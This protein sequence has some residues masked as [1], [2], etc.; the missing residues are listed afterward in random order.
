MIGADTLRQL[1][2]LAPLVQSLA[3]VIQL[4]DMDDAPEAADALAA[5]AGPP[6]RVGLAELNAAQAGRTRPRMQPAPEVSRETIPS[7]LVA[8]AG[9]REL[10]NGLD[11]IAELVVQSFRDR[12]SGSRIIASHVSAYPEDQKIIGGEID[13]LRTA[14]LVASGGLCSPV[15]AFYATDTLVATDARRP[16][17]DSLPSFNAD[18]G[19]VTWNPSPHLSDILID[20]S[21]AAITTVTVAQDAA[22]GTKTVQEVSCGSASTVQVEAIAAR[23]QFSN[24]NDRYSPERVKVYI[25]QTMAA[26]ARQTERLLWEGI[27]NGATIVYGNPVYIGAARQLIAELL[28]AIAGVR[29]RNRIDETYPVNVLLP[30]W[31]GYLVA[32]DL[33]AQQ[34]GDD[35]FDVDG[36]AVIQSA[37]ANVNAR[38]VWS[39]DDARTN[40]PVGAGGPAFSSQSGSGGVLNDFPGRVEALIYPEGQWLFLDGGTLDFGIV[41]DSSLDSQNRFQSFYESFEGIAQVGAA[42]TMSLTIL[43][44]ADGQTSA[45]QTISKCGAVNS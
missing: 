44:C 18:R 23:L 29:Y 14:G 27:R 19:G 41:R 39:R 4:M 30:V 42:E 13:T 2:Q 28:V 1:A 21:Q 33:A 43:V 15:T 36:K 3:P 37:L 9:G 32:V 16:I 40:G 24:F 34:P 20:Q 38:V 10:Y 11:D 22:A 12:W 8:G 7:T 31:A 25:A 26:W 45:A 6:A 17:R 5:A 35:T